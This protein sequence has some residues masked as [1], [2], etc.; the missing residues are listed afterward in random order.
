MSLQFASLMFMSM[1]ES[2]MFSVRVQSPAGAALDI[3]KR[4]N[5][6]PRKAGSDPVSASRKWVLLAQPPGSVNRDIVTMRTADWL[7]DM[8]PGAGILGG[9]VVAAGTTNPWGMDWNEVGEPFFINTVIGHL[10]HVIPGAYYQSFGAP[11][12]GLGFGPDMIDHNHGSTG[13]CG[14]AWYDAD[15][16]PK[17]YLGTMFVG[18]VSALRQDDIKRMLAYSS[19][20]HAGYLV[21]ALVAHTPVGTAAFLYYMAAGDERVARHHA[22]RIEHPGIDLRDPRLAADHQHLELQDPDHLLAFRRPPAAYDVHED[23]VRERGC[24]RQ[25][26]RRQREFRGLSCRC[27]GSASLLESLKRIVLVRR[28]YRQAGGSRGSKR[29]DAHYIL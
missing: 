22:H 10:W 5:G 4:Q 11:H 29:N 26:R 24:A 25:Y 28:S 16:F 21:V 12:D 19:I 9:E 14:V 6:P 15:H 20:A 27:H 8:G 2:F 18:N 3:A 13:I 7:V 23:V 1:T 17:E